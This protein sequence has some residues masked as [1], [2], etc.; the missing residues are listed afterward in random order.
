MHGRVW[1]DCV[2]LATE[3][4][5]RKFGAGGQSELCLSPYS[6]TEQVTSSPSLLF[7]EMEIKASAYKVLVR[8]RLA[9]DAP[10]R[11][12]EFNFFFNM[13]ISFLP[14]ELAFQLGR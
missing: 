4:R 9:R 3:P 7:C 2:P 12:K 14:R 13:L 5:H 8:I 11:G 6:E 10:A 1:G